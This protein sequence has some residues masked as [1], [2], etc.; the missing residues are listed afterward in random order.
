MKDLNIR[1]SE[2]SDAKHMRKWLDDQSVLKWFPMDSGPEIDDS[3]NVCMSYVK[4]KAI[5]TAEYKNQVCGIACLYIQGFKK[6]AHQCLFVII[7]DKEYRG[8]GIGQKLMSE[9]MKLAKE[10]F[11]IKILHL[12]VYDTNPAIYF[13]ERLGFEK[14][15]YQKNFVKQKDGTY[16]GKTMMKKHL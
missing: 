8:K 16:L 9:L 3:I 5:L 14:Y 15:G 2:L 7:L 1:F 4:S 13:Y 11:Q 12:E 6:I 10:R